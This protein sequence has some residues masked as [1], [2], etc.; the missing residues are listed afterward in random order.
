MMSVR[1]WPRTLAPFLRDQLVVLALGK[2][3]IEEGALSP[4]YFRLI[5]VPAGLPSIATFRRSRPLLIVVSWE[6]PR[7]N[8]HIPLVEA[9]RVE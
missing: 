4:M 1:R 7:A 5:Q 2:G 8:S 3:H 9:A 6:L